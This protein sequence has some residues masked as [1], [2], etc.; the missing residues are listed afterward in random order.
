MQPLVHGVDHQRIGIEQHQPEV[1]L[2]AADDGR[3]QPRRRAGAGRI[4]RGDELLA[5]RANS[6]AVSCFSAARSKR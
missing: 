1:G 2:V 5:P 4:E 6:P 3:L